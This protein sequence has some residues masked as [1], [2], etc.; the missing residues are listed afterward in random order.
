MMKRLPDQEHFGSFI[1]KMSTG[2]LVVSDHC[3][4]GSAVNSAGQIGPCFTQ[5]LNNRKSQ[6]W[7]RPSVC[8]VF[9]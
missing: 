8:K 7:R 2:I 1:C 6:S 5:K 9:W 4:P 3:P